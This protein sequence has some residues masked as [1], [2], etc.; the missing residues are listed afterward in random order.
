[1]EP[2]SG[3]GT[4]HTFIVEHRAVVPGFARKLPYAIVN[5]ALEESPLTRVP[6]QLLDADPREVR[7][8]QKVQAEIVALPGG[9]FRIPVFRLAD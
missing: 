1:M 5:V 3:R 9:D 7:I 8:G 4:I 2:V 6:G